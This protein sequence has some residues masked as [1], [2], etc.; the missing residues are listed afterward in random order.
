MKN[1]TVEAKLAWVPDLAAHY[2]AF[3]DLAGYHAIV[4]GLL[5]IILTL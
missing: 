1:G 2:K 3:P 5:T 4:Y